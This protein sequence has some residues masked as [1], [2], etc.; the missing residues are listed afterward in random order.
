MAKTKFA[1]YN[2]QIL[3]LLS[4]HARIKMEPLVRY[5]DYGGNQP[6]APSALT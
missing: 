2:Y 5:L 6:T 3:Q 1:C 4:L